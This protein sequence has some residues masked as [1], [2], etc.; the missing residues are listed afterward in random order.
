MPDEGL[1]VEKNTAIAYAWL[2]WGR[3]YGCRDDDDSIGQEA[4][5]LFLTR[6]S[7][8]SQAERDLTYELVAQ[9]R[10]PARQL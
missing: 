3:D 4:Y 10:V 6:Y 8:L 7:A 9:L 1:G 2:L 5:E